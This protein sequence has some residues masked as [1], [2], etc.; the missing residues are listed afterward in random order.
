MT[1]PL[2]LFIAASVLLS[3]S[4]LLAQRPAAAVPGELIVKPG[5]VLQ[6]RIWPDADLGGEFPIE[7]TG[8]VYLPVLGPV[9][10]GGR[11]FVE[12]RNELRKRYAESMKSP[13]VTITPLVR[14][15]VIGAVAR[16][17]VYYVPPTETIVDVV[18]RA[19]GFNEQA[20]A[21]AIQVARNGRITE[22]KGMAAVQAG[23]SAQALSLRSDDWIIV[24]TRKRFSLGTL[25]A[26][27]Q[28]IT[29][30]AVIWTQV[31]E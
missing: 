25:Q 31:S 24:P 15:S 7:E 8:L 9:A 18:L 19:G 16:P 23:G 5:D 30:G 10:A 4:P 6:V 13:V 29:I 11:S 3:A 22:V 28:V 2:Y 26:V 12:L 14:V 17:G 21:D 20:N 1:R 27:L